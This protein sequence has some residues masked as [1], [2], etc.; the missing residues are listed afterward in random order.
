MTRKEISKALPFW[1]M[2]LRLEDWN[3][4][5]KTVSAKE[6]MHD[7][8]DNEGL[9]FIHPEEMYS[10]ILLRWGTKEET[11]VH[12]LLHLVHDGDKELGPYDILHERALNRVAAAMMFLKKGEK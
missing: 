6:M 9:N 3:V 1:K 8:S 12:E 7:G 4:I 5:V 2:V 10:E 11:L